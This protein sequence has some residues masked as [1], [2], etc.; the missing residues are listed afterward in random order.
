ML[1]G[2]L[3]LLYASYVIDG[4]YKVDDVPALVRPTVEKI[5]EEQ[6]GKKYVE[7]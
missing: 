5:L 4:V 2:S 6:I 1:Y 7:E 3:A